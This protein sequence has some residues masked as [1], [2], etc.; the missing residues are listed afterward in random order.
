MTAQTL[1]LSVVM[2]TFNGERYIDQALRSLYDRPDRPREVILVDDGS[3]DATL[4]IAATFASKLP[5]RIM[6]PAPRHNWL[7]M[8]NLGLD[9]ASSTWSAILHQ[10]DLW[11]PG[12]AERLGRF[13]DSDCALVLM[14]SRFISP[15]GRSLGPW[16]LPRAV[17]TGKKPIPFSTSLYVQNWV[18]VPSATFRTAVVTASGG[19]DESLWYTA[20]WDLWLKLCKEG[21][22]AYVSHLG[23]AF[24]VHASSQTVAGSRNIDNFRQQMIEVQ[25]RH[26]WAALEGA[27]PDQILRA[28]S[29]STE[30][31][32]FLA[33]LLH[34]QR[35]IT[36]WLAALRRARFD[37][38]GAYLAN[39]AL[40]ARSAARLALTLNTRRS[41]GDRR[42]DPTRSPVVVPREGDCSPGE[43]PRLRA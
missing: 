3:T 17:R 25:R 34:D 16:R 15:S 10:D 40:L 41:G 1:D 30:T 32:V 37:G 27:K 11:L 4:D 2:P 19:L 20:D 43:E 33:G 5:L 21:G 13:L 26:R 22:V 14:D 7:A 6:R 39:S 28:G 35:D 31:N 9:E 12:R 42:S 8:T 23:S 38:V 18:A 29:L 36:P 24:R